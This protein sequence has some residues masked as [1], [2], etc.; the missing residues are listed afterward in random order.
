MIFGGGAVGL[1]AL[2]AA[3]LAEPA[4]VVLVDH[5]KTKLAMIPKSILKPNTHLHDS[6][7]QSY[8]EVATELR[9]LTPSRHGFDFALDCVG[10][11]D[12]IKAGHAA[13]DKLGLLVTIGSGSDSNVAGYSLSQHLVKGICHRGTHQGDSVPRDMIPKLLALSRDGQ[14][15]FEQLLSEFGFE[16]MENALGEMKRGTIIKPLL[17]TNM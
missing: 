8:G 5:S 1:A 7:G 14:F 12:V 13:L 3:Q 16:N 9:K 15:P 10:N 2:L 17:V 6:A 11:S 4:C